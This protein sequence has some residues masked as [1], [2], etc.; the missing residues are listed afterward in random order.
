MI[1]AQTSEMEGY[2]A[3]PVPVLDTTTANTDIMVSVLFSFDS[4]HAIPSFLLNRP[5]DFPCL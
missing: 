4:P 1:E 5:L 3:V 2:D